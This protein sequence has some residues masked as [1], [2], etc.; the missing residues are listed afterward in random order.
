MKGKNLG[1][2]IP[3]IHGTSCGVT[4][5]TYSCSQGLFAPCSHTHLQNMNYSSLPSRVPSCFPRDLLRPIGENVHSARKSPPWRCCPTHAMVSTLMR[6]LDHT[7][8]RTIISRTPLDEWSARRRNLYLKTPTLTRRTSMPLA[9]FEPKI[10]GGE[11]PQTYAL[12]AWPLELA[13]AYNSRLLQ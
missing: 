9:E 13:P 5:G 4:T 3:T 12:A 10:S 7:Q 2:V 8:L 6:F 1:C 11:R